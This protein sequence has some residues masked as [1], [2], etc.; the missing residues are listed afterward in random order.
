MICF[1]F[2]PCRIVDGQRQERKCYSGKLKLDSWAKPRI[3]ALETTERRIAEAKLR[4]IAADYEKEAL[5]MVPA[6]S[7]REALSK[8]LSGMPTWRRRVE[9]WARSANTSVRFGCSSN[10]SAGR[11]CAL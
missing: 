8:P 3:F 11:T 7:V 9:A 4:E 10:G 6:R 2:K 5:G 1:V